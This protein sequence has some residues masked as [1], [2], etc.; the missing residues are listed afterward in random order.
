MES[1]ADSTDNLIYPSKN[2][3]KDVNFFMKI[4][5][6]NTID[7]VSASPGNDH[8]IDRS[9]S[10]GM[11][12]RVWRS[13][14]DVAAG[15]KPLE[16]EAGMTVDHSYPKTNQRVLVLGIDI[17]HFSRSVQFILCASGVF[18]FTLVYGY[19]Q[20]LIS[21]Q[22]LNRRMGLFLALFQFSGY[23]FWSMMLRTF[24]HKRT[25][26]RLNDSHSKSS[27]TDTTLRMYI[28][29]SL[30]RAFDLAMTNM[31]MQ[32]INY[33]AKTLLKSSKTLWTML[34]GLV[35]IKKK[36]KLSDY[37]AVMLMVTGLFIFL[38][39][40]ATTSA[41]FEPLG[42][43]ML[44]A[45]LISDGAIS[46]LSETLMSEYNICQD[47][48][49]FYIYSFSTIVIFA[50]A[51]VRGDLLQGLQ[52]ITTPGTMGEIE[53]GL[54]PSW[55]ISGKLTVMILFSTF[56]FFG[57]SCSAAITKNFG[58]LTMSITS[59]SRK[60]ATLFFS[61]LLFPN[62]CTIEHVCGIVL[63]LSSL[64]MQALVRTRK[65]GENDSTLKPHSDVHIV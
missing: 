24:V 29:I 17:S 51:A 1:W 39:A 45:S 12:H 62:H 7:Q 57:S 2:H 4:Q 19:L 40:D 50:A 63:F 64:F 14:S 10:P 36:Y 13:E 52:F 20:E 35:V 15:L 6:E 22:F 41:V 44:V 43:L 55:S 11:R 33:P 32:Y 18:A 56:G 38:H 27:I 34:F 21:I 59:T 9:K 54:A 25:M 28:G 53:S 8:E 30:L 60:A 23:A 58:A 16:V 37:V 61:F 26:S 42:I 46:N 5:N 48:Y 3:R 47:E 31:A 65:E 49:I